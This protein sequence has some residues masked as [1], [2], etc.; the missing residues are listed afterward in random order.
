V[1]LIERA[2][3]APPPSDFL[4]RPF[5]IADQKRFGLAERMGYDPN[6]R[7]LDDTVHPFEI[8]FT[9]DDICITSRSRETWAPGGIFAL[10]HKPGHGMYEQGVAHEFERIPGWDQRHGTDQGSGPRC[11]Q[12]SGT[13][14]KLS[15]GRRLPKRS[16]GSPSKTT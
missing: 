13:T 1:P 3:A 14:L 10:W 2:M 16:S 15:R 5:R 12:G 8:S 9:R 4:S 6:R 11:R 7:R